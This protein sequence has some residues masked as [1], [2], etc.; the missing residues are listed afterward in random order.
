MTMGRTPLIKLSP[1]KT[2]EGFIGGLI[3]T[4]VLSFFFARILAQFDHMICPR[5]NLFVAPSGCVRDFVFT[6]QLETFNLPVIG[7]F[8]F[9]MMPVQKHALSFALFAGSIAPFG[10]TLSLSKD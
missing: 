2:L 6:D 9:M 1:K 8:S 4:I 3:S 5:T 7:E 10:G